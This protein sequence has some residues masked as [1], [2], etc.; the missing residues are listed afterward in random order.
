[1]NPSARPCIHAK[2]QLQL[3]TPEECFEPGGIGAWY[4]CE[5]C[6]AAFR[7]DLRPYKIKVV[8]G[9]PNAER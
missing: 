3:V 7:T 8:M 2:L 6:G 9:V 4:K 1:M 5:N